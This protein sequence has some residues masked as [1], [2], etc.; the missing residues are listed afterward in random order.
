MQGEHDHIFSVKN[1]TIVQDSSP[2]SNIKVKISITCVNVL[3]IHMFNT[4]LA[5]IQSYDRRIKFH[6]KSPFLA[7][8]PSLFS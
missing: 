8:F 5:Q 4:T 1:T 7:Y 6:S 2:I 3:T